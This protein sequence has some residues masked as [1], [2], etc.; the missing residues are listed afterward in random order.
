MNEETKEEVKEEA[1][2]EVKEKVKKEEVLVSKEYI[3]E[4]REVHKNGNKKY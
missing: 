3:E 4:M 1:K 2:E